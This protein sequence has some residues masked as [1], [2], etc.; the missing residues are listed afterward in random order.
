MD[1]AALAEEL[2]AKTIA[3]AGLDVFE[4]EPQLCKTLLDLNNVW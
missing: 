3:G 2:K 1:D 4:G